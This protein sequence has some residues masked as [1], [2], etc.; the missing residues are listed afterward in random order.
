MNRCTSPVAVRKMVDAPI[1]SDSAAPSTCAR[2][3]P[4][5]VEALVTNETSGGG[6]M[7]PKSG[8]NELSQIELL[9]AVRI[10]IQRW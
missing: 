10:A 4:N 3:A 8:H 7:P 5:G 2:R 6:T 9:R 1:A